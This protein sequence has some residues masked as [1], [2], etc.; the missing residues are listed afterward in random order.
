MHMNDA[1]VPTITIY[2]KAL[3]FLIPIIESE[4][5]VISI[6]KSLKDKQQ[7]VEHLIHSTKDN[8]AKYPEF[9]KQ[10]L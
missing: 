7:L 6:I 8:T 2:R 3:S 9:D 1:L 10:I 5:D 4:W